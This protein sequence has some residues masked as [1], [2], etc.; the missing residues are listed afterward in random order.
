MK[1]DLVTEMKSSGMDVKLVKWYP[2][3][4]GSINGLSY[5]KSSFTR[6][7]GDNPVVKVVGYE[8]FNSDE[9]LEII[10]SYRLIESKLWES[11]FNK[12]VNTFDF[13][14]RK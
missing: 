14:I 7:M 6:Q 10:I 13:K 8:F 4:Y 2:I 9:T 11:D 5:I 1:N 3:E 12:I